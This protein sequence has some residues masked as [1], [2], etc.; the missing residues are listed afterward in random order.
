MLH[1]LN[2]G[3]VSDW[4]EPPW[5]DY[6]GTT[7]NGVHGF[8][9]LLGM[10]YSLWNYRFSF[11]GED[12]VVGSG[13]DEAEAES[14]EAEVENDEVGGELRVGAIEEDVLLEKCFGVEWG[15]ECKEFLVGDW[16]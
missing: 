11:E 4:Q 9:Q 13:G 6:A 12:T 14:D 3:G 1:S 16:V 10:T 8:F 7:E 2:N 15:E 5:L